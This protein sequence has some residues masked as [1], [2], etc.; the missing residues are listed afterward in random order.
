MNLTI[1]TNRG[2][3]FG[4]V[5]TTLQ[6]RNPAPE[7]RGF[8]ASI[9]PSMVGR[10]TIYNTR[11]GN[12]FAGL[13]PVV[14]A[15][16]PAYRCGQLPNKEQE[17][18][19]NL[20]ILSQEIRQHDGLYSLNDLHKAAGG[21]IKNQPTRFV[22]NVQTQDL[23]REIEASPNLVKAIHVTPKVGTYVCKELVYAYAMWISPKFHLQ[24]IRA[25]DQMQQP[26]LPDCREN[27]QTYNYPRRLLEQPGFMSGSNPA[28]LCPLMLSKTESFV[29]PLFGLLNELRADGHDVSAPWDEA[30][31]MREG[32]IQMTE[33]LEE[34]YLKAIRSCNKS[35]STRLKG[36]GS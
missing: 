17:T 19:A 15:R 33:T 16:P 29:S 21:E 24:V 30:I 36:G 27:R 35:A 25:F 7:S 4:Q 20:T 14:S 26:A 11:K 3:A 31:A 23:V 1:E 8:F 28:D 9:V 22:R 2:Y 34:I 12:K 13:L 10:A 5:L 32:L 18:M 6:E